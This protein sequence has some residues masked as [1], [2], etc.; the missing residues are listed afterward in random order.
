MTNF[1]IYLLS[2]I[3]IVPIT[4]QESDNTHYRQ[5]SRTR[6]KEEACLHLDSS[7]FVVSSLMVHEAEYDEKKGL[8]VDDLQTWISRLSRMTLCQILTST[9]NEHPN[10]GDE[11]CNRHYKKAYSATKSIKPMLPK[12]EEQDVLVMIQQKARNISHQLDNLRPSEQFGKAHYVYN[13]L[14]QLVRS[15]PI[16]DHDSFVTLFSLIVLAQESLSAPSEVRQHLFYDAKLGRVLI[17]ELA[18]LLKNFRPSFKKNSHLS[19]S[20][21][22]YYWSHVLK[23]EQN[24]LS[25]LE[26]ICSKLSRYDATWEYRNEYQDVLIIAERYHKSSYLSIK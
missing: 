21:D 4:E 13:Q 25:C 23:Q 2:F 3:G 17:L 24:W 19:T 9:I 14:Q 12:E 1:L 6:R 15:L 16:H 7:D 11:I 18:S 5:S 20:M 26:D 8:V 22:Q 10:V